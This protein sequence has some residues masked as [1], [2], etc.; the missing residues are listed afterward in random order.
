VRIL[1]HDYAGHAFPAQLSRELASRGHVVT[2]AFA[3]GLLTPRGAL[4]KK[5][6]DPAGL[7]FVEIAMAEGYRSNKY[8]FVRR[9]RYESAYGVRLAVLIRRLHPDVVISGNTPT[10]P[11]WT[12]LRAAKTAG[13]PFVSWIQDFYG[14]AVDRLI[15]RRVPVL[16]A[17]VGRYYRWLD[18]RC[19]RASAQ[20]ISITEDFAALLA[21]AG[22]APWRATVIHNWAPLVELPVRPRANEWSARHGLDGKCVFLYSGTL[23]MKHNPDLL[24]QLA[25]HFQ[26]DDE[27]RVVV[28]SEGPGSEYLQRGKAAMGL[29]NLVVFPY[30]PFGEMPAVLATGDVLLAVLE[31][32]AGVFSVPSKVLTYH[33]AGRAILAAMPAENL[34]AR[35]VCTVGSGYCVEPEDAARF[36]ECAMQLRQDF[37]LREK[38]GKAGRA[39]AETE[40]NIAR[41]TTQFERV[42]SYAIKGSDR[43]STC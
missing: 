16:G 19:L 29:R 8:N 39:Y 24:L 23:A 4:Q 17:L 34:A 14:L 28:V 15:R 9:R 22:V 41:I 31:R 30:Q 33:A 5:P 12:A 3:G 36:L 2:H 18:G 25:V 10:E 27:V 6:D 43:E 38:Q 21:Q 32:E 1:I 13:V 11:Q 37:R 35:L 40:F 20:V 42:I 26:N 7:E